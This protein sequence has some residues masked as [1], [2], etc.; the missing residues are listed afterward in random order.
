MGVLGFVRNVRRDSRRNQR[1]ARLSQEETR[2]LIVAAAVYSHFLRLHGVFC[3]AERE[4]LTRF[5][6]S[7]QVE[8]SLQLDCKELLAK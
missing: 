3:L 4:E 6:Y 7:F 8:P 5:N 1:T 2:V